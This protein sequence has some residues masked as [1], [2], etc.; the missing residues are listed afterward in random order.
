[1]L[2]C[3]EHVMYTKVT[4]KDVNEIVESHIENGK[5]VTRLLQER[6]NT[7]RSATGSTADTRSSPC[8]KGSH[9]TTAV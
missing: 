9:C 5:I 6:T 8:R 2:V 1:M 4:P 7:K 3:P